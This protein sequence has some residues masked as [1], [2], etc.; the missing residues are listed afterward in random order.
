MPLDYSWTLS[1]FTQA[2]PWGHIFQSKT[3][4]DLLAV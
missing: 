1:Y 3:Q 2:I 4:E